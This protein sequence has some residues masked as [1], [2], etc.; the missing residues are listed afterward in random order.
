MPERGAGLI[1]RGSVTACHGVAVRS[2]D[3]CECEPC[4][5]LE[6]WDPKRRVRAVLVDDSRLLHAHF[7]SF[8]AP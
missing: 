4:L 2:L 5:E 8:V 1:Y 7:S 6:P 3:E